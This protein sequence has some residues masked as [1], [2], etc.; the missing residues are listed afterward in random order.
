MGIFDNKKIKKY[1]RGQFHQQF[2]SI[3]MT[4]L[5]CLK[6]ANT[7]C[8]YIKDANYTFVGN[9]HLRSIS[10]TIGAKFESADKMSLV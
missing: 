10:L 9:W 5:F 8:R 3:F 7:N 1:S 4:I 6:L 2:T